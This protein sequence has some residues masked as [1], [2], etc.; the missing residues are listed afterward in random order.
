MEPHLWGSISELFLC[1]LPRNTPIRRWCATSAVLA[2]T[3]LL[4]T[5]TRRSSAIPIICDR[6]ELENR[7]LH[8]LLHCIQRGPLPETHVP[9]ASLKYEKKICLR[10]TQRIKGRNVKSEENSVWTK[11]KYKLGGRKPKNKA[12][13]KRNPGVQRQLKCKIH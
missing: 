4:S 6:E 13:R 5:T 2:C 8:S 1:Q 7:P 11:Y 12:R 10:D 9:G 3:S